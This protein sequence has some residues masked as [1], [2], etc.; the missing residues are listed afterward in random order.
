M[1]K[2]TSHE[3]LINIIGSTA[4]NIVAYPSAPIAPSGTLAKRFGYSIKLSEFGTALQEL[5][6]KKGAKIPDLLLANEEKKILVVVECKSDFTFELEKRL[7]NQIDFYSSKECEKVFKEMFPNLEKFEVMVVTYEQIGAKIIDFLSNRYQNRNS[8]NIVVWETLI[9]SSQEKVNLKK[10]YGKH[11]D[12]DLN[13]QLEGQGLET[14][15]PR[16]ELLID[17][18]L[19]VGEKVF[20]IGR[21]ILAFMASTYI[22]EADRII[23]IEKFREHHPDTTVMTDGELKKCLR[24]LMILVPEIGDYNS[25]SGEIVLSKRP[26]LDKVKERLESLQD[27]DEGQIKVELTRSTRREKLPSLKRPKKPQKTKLDKWLNSSRS[28]GGYF[29]DEDNNFAFDKLMSFWELLPMDNE[30][31]GTQ[32]FPSEY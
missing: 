13:N 4:L 10:V 22:T 29:I 19:F 23:T 15:K 16:M 28:F 9:K 2:M 20:R 18:T 31:Y 1:G 3:I 30:F 11:L 14:S 7:E 32:H 27:M 6:R 5:M 26:K 12:S 25:G 24:Y 17:P 8:A 21:R